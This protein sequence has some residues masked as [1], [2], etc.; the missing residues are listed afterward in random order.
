MT[1]DDVSKPV[2]IR[3]DEVAALKETGAEG[4][5]LKGIV[6]TEWGGA[7][8]LMTFADDKVLGEVA[9]LALSLI[10]ESRTCEDVFYDRSVVETVQDVAIRP[11]RGEVLPRTKT[12]ANRGEVRVRFT[13]GDA[14]VDLTA[15]VD[16]WHHL[17][18]DMPPR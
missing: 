18:G 2:S 12:D 7:A 10:D 3:A 4:G 17:L 15:K 5:Y 9:M 11:T 14:K 16:H 8:A 1:F 13:I 6:V